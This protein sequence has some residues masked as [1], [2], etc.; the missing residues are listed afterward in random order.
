MPEMVQTRRYGL[1]Y[2][3]PPVNAWQ[4]HNGRVTLAGDAAHSMPP[5]RGQGLNNAINDAFNLVAAITELDNKN[6]NEYINLY[7]GEVAERG[8]KEVELSKETAAMMLDYTMFRQ[9]AL[10]TKGLQKA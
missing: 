7:S 8:A 6:Q 9:S 3:V 2:W 10:M 4:T 5:H 1:G